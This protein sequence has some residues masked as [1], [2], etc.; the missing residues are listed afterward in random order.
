MISEKEYWKEIYFWIKYRNYYLVHTK[1]SYS[2]VWLAHKQSSK[3]SIFHYGAQSSQDI[4]FLKARV[5]EHYN[6]IS[7]HLDF[8]PKAFN[9]YIF[10][11]VSLT[12]NLSTETNY[13]KY[14][15]RIINSS[16]YFHNQHSNI[17]YKWSSKLE[18]KKTKSHY[19][20]LVLND[21]PIEKHMIRF[22]PITYSLIA[23]NILIWLI[24]FLVI[25]RFSDIKLLDVGGLVHFNFVH[26]E[27]YRLITSMFLHFNLE[28]LFMNMISLFIFGKIVE[29]I[30]GH[31]RM[32]AIYL[33]SGIFG[34][35][36]SLSFNTQTVSAGASGAIFGLIG[37]IFTFMFIAKTFNRKMVGQLLIVLVILIGISIFIPNIN[38]IAHIGGLI[39][40]VLITLIGY[41]YRSNRN[42]F[43]ITLIIALILFIIAQ[44]RIYTIQEKNIYN[45]IIANEMKKGDYSSANKMV[46]HTISKHYDDDYTYYLKGLI[47]ASQES[48]TEAIS[49]WQRGLRIYPRSSILNYELAV[50]S[51]ALDNKQKA[52]KYIKKAVSEDPNNK[53]YQRLK[54]E[55]D[56]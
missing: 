9:I 54:D 6:D 24:M 21:N 40:G 49:V 31:W 27:W 10:T 19:K 42:A 25:N 29:S 5:E 41:Y 46:K 32:L 15:Y 1:D 44:I 30:V 47:T 7:Q 50:A 4:R 35:F 14:D 17:F 28:H 43:W 33:F 23:L 34:N 12:E 16:Q 38:I 11:D 55:L 52:K 3:I 56:D 26:G 2:E 48:K 45:H 13:A 20:R 8:K 51:R 18:G 37:A 36:A 53:A 22:A 39:G